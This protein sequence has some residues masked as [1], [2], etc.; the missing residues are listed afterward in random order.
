MLHDT[1]AEAAELVGRGLVVFPLPEG[2]RRPADG[3]WRDTCF[4][5]AQEVE[6]RWPA[7]ANIGVA[8]AASHLV[9]L[10][11]DDVADG[12]ARNGI[13]T[14][15][16]QLTIRGLEDWPRTLT[17]M[18]PSGGMHLYFR[19][20]VGRIIRSSSGGTSRLGPG[21]DIRAPGTGRGGYL[22]GPGSRVDGLLYTIVTDAPII[23]LP[24]WITNLL[25]EG[26]S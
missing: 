9:G 11:L 26:T 2:G 16:T 21:I 10:D 23:D 15:R 3:S 19:A 18:T 22:I 14:L 6:L 5:T 13:E 17:V 20:P 8:C 25:S 7:D 4:S 24:D 1:T 12:P